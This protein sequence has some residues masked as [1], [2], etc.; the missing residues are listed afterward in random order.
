MALW[1]IW[2][3]YLIYVVHNVWCVPNKNHNQNVEGKI[4]INS[5]YVFSISLPFACISVGCFILQ[6]F[7]SKSSE[8]KQNQNLRFQL[9][10]KL[11]FRIHSVYRWAVFLVCGAPT[12]KNTHYPN[13]YTT[14]FSFIRTNEK[15]NMDKLYYVMN[16]LYFV[17]SKSFDK[18][19]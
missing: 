4:H 12:K 15:K 3:S 18:M 9:A 6:M 2:F 11:S 16:E 7:I 5:T 10:C 17:P 8:N 1:Q 19:L 13:V 14:P